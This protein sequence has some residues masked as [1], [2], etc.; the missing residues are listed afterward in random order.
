[1]RFCIQQ[2]RPVHT[3]LSVLFTATFLVCFCVRCET[4]SD[5]DRALAEIF[6][7]DAEQRRAA[8]AQNDAAS[9]DPNSAVGC[10]DE[11]VA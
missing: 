11:S 4:L 9:G 6:A 2:I 1:M 10:E 8:K 5:I 3:L 7:Q